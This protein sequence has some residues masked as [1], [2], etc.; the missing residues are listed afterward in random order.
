MLGLLLAVIG[1]LVYLRGSNLDFLYNKTGWAFAA[2]VSHHDFCFPVTLTFVAVQVFKSFCIS[3]FLKLVEENEVQL[4]LF[5]LR[6]IT[7]CDLS[8]FSSLN[9]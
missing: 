6:L 4:V 8:P 9:A 3:R 7:F 2:L 5:F 1:G